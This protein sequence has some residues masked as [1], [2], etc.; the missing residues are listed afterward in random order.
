MGNGNQ[1]TFTLVSEEAGATDAGIELVLGDGR[2]LHICQGVDEDVR[3]SENFQGRKVL[4]K[5]HDKYWLPLI[6]A[7][8]PSF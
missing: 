7:T 3:A 2:R 8:T 6:K 1:A 4:L 5:V